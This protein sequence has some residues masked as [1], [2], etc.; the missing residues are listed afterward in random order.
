MDTS[1]NDPSEA[2]PEAHDRGASSVRRDRDDVEIG[3]VVEHNALLTGRA[4]ESRQC[5]ARLGRRFVML[6]LRGIVHPFFE[7]SSKLTDV[8]LE[9]PH[10][11]GHQLVIAVA[12]DSP[13]ARPRALA[14]VEQQTGPTD[15]FVVVELVLG[16]RPERKGHYQFVDGRAEGPHVDERTEVAHA[17][18]M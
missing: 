3:V 17:L 1:S 10:P 5:V 15:P 7:Q 6:L 12:V 11:G 2:H 9:E 18:L 8:T 16:A 14:D 13:N 4:L